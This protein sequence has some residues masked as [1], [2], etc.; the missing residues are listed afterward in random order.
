MS[1]MLY[2]LGLFNQASLFQELLVLRCC[3]DPGVQG[4][5]YDILNIFAPAGNQPQLRSVITICDLQLNSQLHSFD[6]IPSKK[7]LNNAIQARPNFRPTP[8]DAFASMTAFT[9][10]HEFCHVT[11]F[12]KEDYIMANGLKA[13]DWADVVSIG[14]ANALTNVNNVILSN[15]QLQITKY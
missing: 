8:V 9:I 3:Q 11:P 6:N 7:D 4:Q 12:S 2:D 14:T 5:T 13:Y 1:Q 15:I 10:M